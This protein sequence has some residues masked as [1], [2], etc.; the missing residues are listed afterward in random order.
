[1]S[2]GMTESKPIIRFIRLPEVIDRTGLK[3]TT[4][5]DRMKKGTFPKS[6]PLGRG[7]VVWNESDITRWQEHYIQAGKNGG[8]SGGTNA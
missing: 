3:T 4:I 5:Y 8:I 6:I 7:I 2:I 1:M